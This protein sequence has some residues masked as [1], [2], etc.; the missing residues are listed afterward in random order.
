MKNLIALFALAFALI[1]EAAVDSL[2]IG[3]EEKILNN[4][5][6]NTHL[7]VINVQVYDKYEDAE[8]SKFPKKFLFMDGYRKYHIEETDSWESMEALC[9]RSAKS[10]DKSELKSL[11]EDMLSQALM[12]SFSGPLDPTLEGKTIVVLLGAN[13]SPT[14]TVQRMSTFFVINHFTLRSESGKWVIPES[15]H[16]VNIY[17]WMNKVK[18]IGFFIPGVVGG[19]MDGIGLRPGEEGE[20]KG[21]TKAEKYWFPED[22]IVFP[23]D[24]WFTEEYE[25][26]LTTGVSAGTIILMFKDGSIQEFS[27][28]DGLPVGPVKEP[29]PLSIKIVEG[30]IELSG[31]RDDVII[32]SSKDLTTWKEAQYLSKFIKASPGVWRYPL[33]E[34]Y[35]FFKAT[36]PKQSPE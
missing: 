18:N 5:L 2:P 31:S 8:A 7:F 3:S 35:R 9:K 23:N 28:R 10:S 13:W 16:E 27:L 32:Y 22:Y 34:G 25:G 4:A 20:G 24:L 33:S 30:V 29:Y 21:L 12:V 14:E 6:M 19:K 15:A 11:I 26:F 36:V 1:A 17:K